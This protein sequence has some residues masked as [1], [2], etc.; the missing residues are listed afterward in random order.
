MNTGKVIYLVQYAHKS[1]GFDGWYS[2]AAY[3]T[4]NKALLREI[5]ERR[6]EPDYLY[7]ISEVIFIT[8]EREY[9]KNL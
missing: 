2:I 4:K 5:H 7:R 9:A 3:P 6:E 1:D 8:E